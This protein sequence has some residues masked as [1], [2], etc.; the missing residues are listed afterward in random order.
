MTKGMRRGLCLMAT[1]FSFH[2]PSLDAVK[3]RVALCDPQVILKG[4]QAHSKKFLQA[5][6]PGS[7]QYGVGR[8]RCPEGCLCNP[9]A[10]DV[11][12]VHVYTQQTPLFAEVQPLDMYSVPLC[13]LR[14]TLC[15]RVEHMTA[16]DW[17][18]DCY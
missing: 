18:H 13:R 2:G 5:F 8:D 3:V 17:A 9:L 16:I 12:I 14:I 1:P 7:A 6:R 4:A 15:Q 11:Q 10:S